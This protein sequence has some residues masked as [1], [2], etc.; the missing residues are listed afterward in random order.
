MSLLSSTTKKKG[1]ENEKVSGKKKEAG[2]YGEVWLEG[3]GRT[4]VKS[5][6]RGIGTYI[7]SHNFSK[8]FLGTCL[9]TLDGG[10]GGLDGDGRRVPVVSTS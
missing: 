1:E 8:V 3:R 10:D 9:Q 7:V 5:I 2:S 4:K 6:C